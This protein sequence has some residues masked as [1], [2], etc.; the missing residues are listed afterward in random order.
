[1][2][3][4]KTLSYIRETSSFP[5]D[6]EFLL[7]SSFF[8]KRMLKNEFLRAF[9]RNFHKKIHTEKVSAA[10]WMGASS[11]NSSSKCHRTK[12]YSMNE[13]MKRVGWEFQEENLWKEFAW[14]NKSSRVE[15][16]KRREKKFCVSVFGVLIFQSHHLLSLYHVL[17]CWNSRFQRN[18]MME[19]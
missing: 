9:A 2:I 6:D 4:S 7:S 1:M 14:N 19:F 17:L 16:M 13:W 18:K 3:Y 11:A 15:W 12:R 8:G 10:K 5:F